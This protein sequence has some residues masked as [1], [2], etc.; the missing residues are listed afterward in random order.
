MRLL[1]RGP[2]QLATA[3]HD[4]LPLHV[5]RP[6]VPFLDWHKADALVA[7]CS[8]HGEEVLWRRLSSIY[9]DDK[10]AAVVFG[11]RNLALDVARDKSCNLSTSD[12]ED[13]LRTRFLSLLDGTAKSYVRLFAALELAK[14]RRRLIGWPRALNEAERLLRQTLKLTY[15][16]DVPFPKAAQTRDRVRFAYAAQLDLKKY[17]Q[18][19]EL[20]A[21]RFFAVHANGRD[22]GLA[23]IPTGAVGPPLIAQVLTRAMCLWAT[24]VTG[25][26]ASVHFDTMIDNVRFVSDSFPDL[27]RAWDALLDCCEKIGVTIGDI[28]HPQP[29]QLPYEFLG[30][31]FDHG[32]R[33][34]RPTQKLLDKLQS[35]R[36]LLEHGTPV[37]TEDLAAA[38]GVCVWASVVTDTPMHPYYYVLKF[39]RRASRRDDTR[40]TVWDS[41]KPVWRSW[42]DHVGTTTFKYNAVHR[43][44]PYVL[45][46]DA[47]NHGWGGVCFH[48]NGH[49]AISGDSWTTSESRFDINVKEALAVRKALHETIAAT[50]GGIDIVLYIDNTTVISNIVKRRSPNFVANVITGEIHTL[51]AERN[52]RLAGINYVASARNFADAPSRGHFASPEQ[53]SPHS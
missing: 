32:T 4:H 17:F 36:Q 21:K 52:V 8:P 20:I 42:I 29:N 3:K 24:R 47:S 40:A 46:T 39:M 41:V 38:F 7:E 50:G 5:Q 30:M 49:V 53:L 31:I 26:H 45:F 11:I 1:A 27:V 43:R 44:D 34:V 37:L 51:A 12:V 22:Y 28:Q 15:H 25:T 2:T 16:A 10:E 35:A 9:R 48:P 19:Y 33:T 23:T 18:Q 14:D 13:M 6:P